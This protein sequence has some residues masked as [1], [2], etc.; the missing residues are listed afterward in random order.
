[1]F[2][3]THL[4]PYIYP[5]PS[6]FSNLPCCVNWYPTDTEELYKQNIKLPDKR[7]ILFDN[8]WI[9]TEIIYQINSEGF[10]TPEFDPSKKRFM[11][12]GC[13]FTKGIGLPIDVVWPTLLSNDLGIEVDNLAEQGASNGLIFRIAQ[14]WIP[15]LKP[16][17]VVVQQTMATRFEILNNRRR[18][19]ISSVSYNTELMPPSWWASDF[20]SLID[21]DRNELAIRYICSELN[22]PVYFLPIDEFTK[23]WT[24]IDGNLITRGISLDK[25]RDA[26]HPGKAVHRAVANILRDRINK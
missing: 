24:E 21:A 8:N 11:T 3:R 20:N 5:P 4:K 13:S 18:G 9:D 14:H 2:G 25:A 1:M 12:L 19:T 6:P 16:Q 15:I 22:I 10:R 7:Q 23:V 17:F 26:M